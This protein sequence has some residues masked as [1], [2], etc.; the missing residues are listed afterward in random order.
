M[1]D[2]IEKAVLQYQEISPSVIL[3]EHTIV[4]ESLQGKG[5]GKLLAEVILFI[6]F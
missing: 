2:F 5:F 4:P 1:I 3:I 6:Y